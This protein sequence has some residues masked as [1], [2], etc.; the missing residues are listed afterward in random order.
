MVNLRPS[1]YSPE[2]M[3]R[4]TGRPN[5]IPPSGRE[6]LRKSRPPILS[7]PR[8]A[9]LISVRERPPAPAAG[10]IFKI[11]YSGERDT[12]LVD[13]S[14]SKMRAAGSAAPSQYDWAAGKTIPPLPASKAPEG[15]TAL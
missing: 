6:R 12:V 8:E 4:K 3:E 9:A 5:P 11:E 1:G 15:K 13:V 14:P 7:P 2:G 10:V